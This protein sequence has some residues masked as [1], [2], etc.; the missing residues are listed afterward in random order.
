MKKKIRVL[1]TGSRGFVG[2]SLKKYLKN[3]IELD[4]ICDDKSK[5]DLS[6][7][8][9]FKLLLKKS[10][11]N[12][13]I[14]LASRTVSGSKSI[15]ED[16]LQF[17]NTL[18]PIKNLIECIK[19]LNGVQKLIFIGTIEEY[20]K[21]KNPYKENS[22]AKPISSYG[23]FKLKCFNF[24]KKNLTKNNIKYIWLRPSLM[25]GPEDNKE[26]FLG[27]IFYSAKE[28]KMTAINLD[29]QIRDYLFVEDFNRF[30][31]LHLIK[32]E[33]PKLRVLNVTNQNWLSLIQVMN[34]LSKMSENKIKKYLKIYNKKDNS[35]LIN[36]GTLFKKYYP[37]FKFTD[38]KYALKKTLISYNIK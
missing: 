34:M 31:Y 2:R 19:P 20:G 4:V 12:I 8:F 11:P 22:R 25:F 35:K 26:R 5:F 23:S 24:V 15:Q 38:F 6:K 14:H 3:K 13:I 17:K 7:K 33:L 29:K 10:K 37:N 1:I 16:K 30:V 36:S 32:K 9:F 27:S 28:K 18:K 21:A